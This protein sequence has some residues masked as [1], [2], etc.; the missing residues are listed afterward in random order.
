MEGEHGLMGKQVIKARDYSGCGVFVTLGVWLLWIVG[1]SY[2][3]LHFLC[4]WW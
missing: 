2:V 1:L 4:K 3:I